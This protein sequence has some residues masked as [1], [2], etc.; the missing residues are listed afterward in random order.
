M[1]LSGIVRL[2]QQLKADPDLHLLQMQYAEGGRIE[3]WSMGS[4]AVRVR[5]GATPDEVHTAFEATA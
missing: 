5:A 2:R 3:V 4:R 1:S